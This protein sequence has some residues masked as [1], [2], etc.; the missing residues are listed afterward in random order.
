[1]FWQIVT[2]QNELLPK[3]RGN[4]FDDVQDKSRVDNIPKESLCIGVF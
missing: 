4:I 1:M 3:C 2:Q